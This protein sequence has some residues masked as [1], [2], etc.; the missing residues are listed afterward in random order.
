LSLET[1]SLVKLHETVNG[2]MYLLETDTVICESLRTTGDYAPD[3]KAL[4]GPLISSGD[5]ILDVGANVGNHTL[6]FSQCVG[7]GGRVLSF[8]PQ[9]FLFKILCANALLG[10]YQNVWPY[11]LAVGDEEGTVDIPVPNSERPN[12]FGG[13]SLSFDKF[14]EAADITTIDTIAPD[15]CHLIKID[16]EGME[17]S[18]LRGA[19]ETIARTRPFLYFEYNRPEFKEEIL[20][21][22]ADKLRYRL[23]RHGQNVVG[24]HA[25]EAPPQAVANLTEITPEAMPTVIK[26]S[27]SSGKIFVS[28]AC[29]CDPD[30]VDT[31]RDCLERAVSPAR[32]QIGV[33][34][35]AKPNDASYDALNDI[36]G[37]MVDRIDVTEARGPIYARARCESLMKDADYFLQIDCHSRF[38]QGWDEIL[39]QEF[40][41]ASELNG[42]AV[43]SHYPMNIKNMASS[44]HLD[45]IGQVNRYRYIE[46]DAIKSHGSLIKLPGVP[47]TSLGISAAMLFMRAED[48]KRFPYDPELDFGLHA[49]EQ[50]LYAVRLW[51]HG[52]DIFCPTQHALATD[53]E[54]SRDRI[55]DEVKRI[56]NANRT[57]WP[58]ATWSKVKYLL[59]LD[60]IEQVDPVYG[61]TLSDSMA[62]FGVGD[63]RSLRSYYDFAGIHDELRRVFPNY[64][65]AKD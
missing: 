44:D 19:V 24:H 28:I 35:Q 9:R 40:A 56:S 46:A 63:E 50:V 18:V 14:K 31:V 36:A 54:G 60:D 15:Q 42:N 38:F 51:T 52:F 41:K 32:I 12:N 25:D 61:D 6:F 64:R 11:R 2:P 7:P 43:L 34:L 27:G 65:Y 23:Y 13:Y 39:I 16:V 57:G 5:T 47:A 33:C 22:S 3:E 21:F 48:R 4:L 26:A 10:R 55:P 20:R 59:G 8:E 49:A 62:R 1:D 53:Y 58:E 17:L 29:F 30:V 45:R 37:V